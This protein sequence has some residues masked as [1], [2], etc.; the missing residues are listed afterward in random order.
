MDLYV[1]TVVVALLVRLQSF[2]PLAHFPCSDCS[3]MKCA[4]HT[5]QLYSHFWHRANIDTAVNCSVIVKISLGSLKCVCVCGQCH[6]LLLWKLATNV[7]SQEI[8]RKPS[9]LLAVC[10]SQDT[11]AICNHNTQRLWA[12]EKRLGE[13]LYICVEIHSQRMSTCLNHKKD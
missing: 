13:M 4:L 5:W 10:Q 7:V 1:Y 12:T 8:S 2:S 11:K 6:W 9:L 3:E